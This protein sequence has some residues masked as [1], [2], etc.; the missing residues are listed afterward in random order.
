MGS[1][2]SQAL[3]TVSAAWEDDKAQ[4]GY[5]RLLAPLHLR[6]I[7]PA[8]RVS[9]DEFALLKG[10]PEELPDERDCVVLVAVSVH[11]VGDLCFDG[12]VRQTLRE[13]RLLQELDED[14]LPLLL[15]TDIG[16][17]AA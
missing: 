5:S 3:W 11:A 10:I 7:D 14:T 6:E 4:T 12:D 16:S 9:I 8:P 2:A 17:L 1:R 15:E 13:T